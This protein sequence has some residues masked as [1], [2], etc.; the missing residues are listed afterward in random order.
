MT[1]LACYLLRDDGEWFELGDN[2]YQ[3]RM[4]FAVFPGPAD[5][6]TRLMPEDIELLALR[7]NDYGHNHEELTRFATAI[8]EWAAGRSF[9]FITE[10]CPEIVDPDVPPSPITGRLEW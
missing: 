2:V 4:S 8:I 9:K 6:S 10:L 1:T 5:G 7:L 3:W